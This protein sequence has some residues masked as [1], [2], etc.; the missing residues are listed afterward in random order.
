MK[1]MAMTEEIS[2][3]MKAV[4][5]RIKSQA[6]EKGSIRVE[7]LPTFYFRLLYKGHQVLVGFFFFCH[8]TEFSWSLVEQRQKRI[9]ES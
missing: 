7:N 9:K 1:A 8:F 2:I 6:R 4:L 3:N 5:L